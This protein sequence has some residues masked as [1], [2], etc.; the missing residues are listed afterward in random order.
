MLRIKY[1]SGRKKG[2][3][4]ECPRINPLQ[5]LN[6]LLQKNIDWELNMDGATDEQQIQRAQ[7][8]HADYAF[9]IK[10]AQQDERPIGFVFQDELGYNLFP[11]YCDGFNQ[12][13]FTVLP[14][15]VSEEGT[16]FRLIKSDS[17]LPDDEE[18]LNVNL[19]YYQ[20]G[21]SLLNLV[22]RS[23]ALIL[24][25][26]DKDKTSLMWTVM[27]ASGEKATA[28]ILRDDKRG[29]YFCIDAPSPDSHLDIEGA[30]AEMVDSAGPI[31]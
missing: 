1:L 25:F 29:L 5:F 9:R 15:E 22:D 19:L 6:G 18:M 7:W 13:G 16:F 30:V 24:R 14:E 20:I 21:K 31:D 27:K 26:N 23:M 4:E 28:S 2:Q 8:Q 11:I 12:I 10:R 17:P 3:V